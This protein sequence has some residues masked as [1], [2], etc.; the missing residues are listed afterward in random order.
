MATASSKASAV[1]N[2]SCPNQPPLT[3]LARLDAVER[4]LEATIRA[5]E[6]VRPAL[7]TLYDSLNDEQRQRLDAIGAEDIGHGRGTAANGSSG[8]TNLASLCSDQAA[9]FTRLPVQRIEE[10]VK[11]TGQQQSALERLKQT[12]ENA[13]DELRASCPARTAE[14]PVARLDEMHNRLGAM[15][16]AVK[17]LRPTL[18]TFYASLSD[19]QKAQFNT[20]GQQNAGD[21]N[22]GR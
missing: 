16:Q 21:T 1:L 20:M 19:E 8:A 4:R 9:N 14:A 6:I 3:P 18:G 5:I 11:P 17:N 15:V 22:G 12:S 13:A 10:V 2:A 7:A